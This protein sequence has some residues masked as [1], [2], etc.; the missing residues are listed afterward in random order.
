MRP[1]PTLAALTVLAVAA[2]AAQGAAAPAVL[3]KAGKADGLGTVVV[4]ATG[5]TLYH[6]AGET[7]SAFRCTA[8]CAEQWVPLTVAPGGDAVAGKGLARAKLGTVKRPD[9][10]RQ[11]TYNGL[12]LYR[13]LK[14]TKAGEAYGQGVENVWYAVTPAGRIT[15]A[16]AAPARPGLRPKGCAILGASVGGPFATGTSATFDFGCN[17]SADGL[18]IQVPGH[19][20]ASVVASRPADTCSVSGETVGCKLDTSSQEEGISVAGAW[21]NQLR[22]R[23]APTDSTSTSGACGFPATVT[24]TLGGSAALTKSIVLACS[25]QAG[26]G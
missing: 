5:K 4:S 21:A 20:I 14:D 12:T 8:A 15:K 26:G 1:L 23:F 3:V 11:V 7:K 25:T 16:G 17:F 24:L 10:A 22:W 2:A 13:Y 19:T 9:G 6:R 18:Q